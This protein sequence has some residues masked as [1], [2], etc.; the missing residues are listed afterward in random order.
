MAPFVVIVLGPACLFLLYALFQ[1]WREA[2]RL[3][4]ET[5]KHRAAAVRL[6]EVSAHSPQIRFRRPD[7]ANRTAGDPAEKTE[8]G[9]GGVLTFRSGVNR[10]AGRGAA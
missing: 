3:R 6:L 2:M 5:A 8:R 9:S 7:D 1:F 10:S 4:A